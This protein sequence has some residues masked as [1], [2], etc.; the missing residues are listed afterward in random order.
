MTML[1]LRT[2][3]LGHPGFVHLTARIGGIP[4][5]LACIRD[6]RDASFDVELG[7][8]VW[9]NSYVTIDRGMDRP[10][11][12]GDRSVL[13]AKAH[14][15][16]D[17]QVGADCVLAT[18]CIVGGS[19]TVGDRVKVGLG[20]IVLPCRTVGDDVTIGAGAVVT[21]D[22]PAGVTVV[23]NPARIVA[24]NPVPHTERTARSL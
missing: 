13:L 24:C 16:H 1:E 18:G 23:G 12:I 2:G 19:C 4:E 9:V 14:V 22:V 11:T 8:D 20:A 5:H 7:D 21:K 17:A 3:W 6:G 10:T 15:G